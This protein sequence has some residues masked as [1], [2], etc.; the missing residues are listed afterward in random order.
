MGGGKGE[1]R[2]WAFH[3]CSFYHINISLYNEA[4]TVGAG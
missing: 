1:K 4:V 3:L 2:P